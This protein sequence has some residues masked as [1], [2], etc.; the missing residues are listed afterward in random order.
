MPSNFREG[1][2]QK[3]FSTQYKHF[4]PTTPEG[5]ACVLDRIRLN[6][7]DVLS[8]LSRDSLILDVACGVGYLE[9]YLLSQGFQS[10]ESIDISGEQI[11]IAKQK[12]TEYGVDFDG[13]VKFVE[14]SAFDYLGKSDAYDVVVMFDIIEHFAK[15]KIGQLLGLSYTALRPGGLLLLRTINADNPLFGRSFYHDFTH[16]TPF[17]PDSIRQCMAAVG[18]RINKLDYEKVGRSERTLMGWLKG[19]TRSGGLRAL[20]KLLGIPHAAFAEN[21]IVVARK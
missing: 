1:L 17:T 15:E 18:F 3:Y 10:L 14:A 2:D 8:P 6:F 11:A 19:K 20:A 9:H 16:E 4:M 12:L 21:L 7:E 13:R 5:W